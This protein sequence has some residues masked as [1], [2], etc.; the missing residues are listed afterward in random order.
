MATSQAAPVDSMQDVTPTL[1][2][3]GTPQPEGE[4]IVS[5]TL[6]IQNLNEKV[7][8]DGEHRNIPQLGHD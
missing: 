3:N 8:I 1:A 5:E 7:K 4:E 6:Y 2:E